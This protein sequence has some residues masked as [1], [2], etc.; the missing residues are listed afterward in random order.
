[1]QT[2]GLS[3]PE[4]TPR[5]IRVGA[6]DA[7][8]LGSVFRGAFC[9]GGTSQS[10]AGTGTAGYP[11]NTQRLRQEGGGGGPVSVHFRPAPSG[12]ATAGRGGH[13]GDV[14]GALSLTP[15]PGWTVGVSRAR[16][17]PTHF[18]CFL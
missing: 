1:M 9:S 2:L 3:T 8:F 16:A 12:A 11:G 10:S 7:V 13:S 17:G 6:Q 18:F 15:V 4:V 14:L 5:Q